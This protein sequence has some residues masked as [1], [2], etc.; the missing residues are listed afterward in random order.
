MTDRNPWQ[1]DTFPPPPPNRFRAYIWLAWIIAVGVGVWALFRLFPEVSLSSPQEARVF[2][3]AALAVLFGSSIVFGR[4]FSWSEAARNVAI[5]SGIAAV[6]IAFY[7]Y[8]D[9][10]G[11]FGAR[12][13]SGFL[14]TEPVVA[15]AD[16][17][18]LTETPQEDYSAT[19][20]VD[21][22]RVRFIV[23]TGASDI[24]LSPDDARRAGIDTTALAYDRETG[25]A[26]GIGH[27]AP[28]TLASLT[29]GPIHL[30]N[31]PVLIDQA[32]MDGSLLG[33][34]FLRRL[35]SFEFKD[36]RLVMRWR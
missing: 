19:G 1:R 11:D 8:R 32:P 22:V 33:L 30:T 21:G 13:R 17:V 25:T 14:P 18:V 31:V 36:H 6:L 34:S 35:K 23:D 27:G 10:L 15:G 3:L 4:R 29:L 12:V 16:T 5:W 24:V 2:Y 28:F 20:E 9:D 7:L 26:N